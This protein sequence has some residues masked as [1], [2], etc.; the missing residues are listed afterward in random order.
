VRGGQQ[1]GEM[2]RTG[3]AVDQLHFE[4]RRAGRPVDPLEFLPVR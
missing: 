4:I 1:I 3:A 2:G